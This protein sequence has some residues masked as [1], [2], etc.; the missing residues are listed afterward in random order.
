[1]IICK[2]RSFLLFTISVNEI[3]FFLFS[4]KEH[5]FD[6]IFTCVDEECSTSLQLF[7]YVSAENCSFPF[8]Q[9]AKSFKDIAGC[10]K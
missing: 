6:F 9:E 2:P 3:F 8:N 5:L 7:I 10:F 4:S 1:M